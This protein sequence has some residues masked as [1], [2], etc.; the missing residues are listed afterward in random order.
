MDMAKRKFRVP[1]DPYYQPDPAVKLHPVGSCSGCAGRDFVRWKRIGPWTI[2]RCVRCGLCFL[3][4]RPD[5]A[6]LYADYHERL[7][8]E[9]APS[10]EAIQ[11]GIAAWDER[12]E[13]ISRFKKPGRALDLGCASGFF[14]ANL[15]KRGWEVAGC[16][17]AAWAAQHARELFEQIGRAHV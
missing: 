11:R 8:I 9:D 14:L 6:E 16:E 2:S 4:P 7:H 17:V 5:A 15:R 1:L 12:V 3:D 13:K 10:P